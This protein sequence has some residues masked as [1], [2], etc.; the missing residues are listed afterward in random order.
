MLEIIAVI[1]IAGALIASVDH[2]LG[3]PDR[4]YRERLWRRQR[5]RQRRA[6]EECTWPR[7]RLVRE[8]PRR[9]RSW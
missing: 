7:P 5:E 2:A 8:V 1:V 6:L 4:R 3:G 9:G